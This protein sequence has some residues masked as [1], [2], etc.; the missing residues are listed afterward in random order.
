MQDNM[1][2]TSAHRQIAE[3]SP[4]TV[5]YGISRHRSDTLLL[6]CLTNLR[7]GSVDLWKT[8]HPG[9]CADIDMRIVTR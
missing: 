5:E 7:Y 3:T 1:R 8:A 4:A 2:T 6:P 9:D